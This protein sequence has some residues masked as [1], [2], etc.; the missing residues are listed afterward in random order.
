M[1]SFGYTLLFYNVYTFL[2]TRGLNPHVGY[3]HPLRQGHPA[4]ASDMMEEFRAIIVDSVVFNIAINNKLKPDDF[5]MPQQ[6][7]E[8]CLLNTEARK[9]F[10]RQL[11]AKLNTRI[12]HPISGL[13]LDYRRC[14]EHQINHLVSVLRQGA[15]GYQTMILR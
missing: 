7:G 9:F 4:L 11:E 2:R 10:I 3:L 8:G 14:I 6:S 15:P 5:I 13:Q 12:R 1:L